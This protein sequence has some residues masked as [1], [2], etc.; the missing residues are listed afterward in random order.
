MAE[1]ASRTARDRVRAELTAEIVA[2]ARTHL[3]EQ[4]SNSLSLRAV[5]RDL[6]MA[7]SALYRY[8]PSRDALLTT[9][10]IDAYNA[11]GEACEAADASCDRGDLVGRWRAIAH[12]ARDWARA[13]PHEY[14]LIYGTPVPGYHAPIDTIDPA[15]RLTQLLLSLMAD[16]DNAGKPVRVEAPLPL[17]LEGQLTETLQRTGLNMSS[18]T[19]LAGIAAWT[20]LFGMISFEVFGRFDT[21]FDDTDSLFAH[22]IDLAADTLGLLR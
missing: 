7:S 21:I 9:L 5:A 1:S 17:G 12:A 22:Q 19:L 20:N 3:I 6:G 15:S 10:I 8:F 13:Y 4:G 11:I 16:I 18:G 14:A 2:M